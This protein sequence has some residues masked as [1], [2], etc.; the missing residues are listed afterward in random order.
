M[1]DKFNM[2]NAK[3]VSTPL[4]KHFKLYVD[5]CP[6]TNVEVE[7]MSKVL[8][9][10]AAVYLMYVMVCTRPSLTYVVSQVCKFMSNPSK[11]H[12]EAMK[13]SLRYLKDTA[14][15]GIMLGH[16]QGDPSVVGYMD[17]DY[18]GDLD[19]KRFTTGYVFTLARRPI[20]WK[21]II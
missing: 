13:W 7:Y 14:S 10:S 11:R 18:A 12:W 2:S 3:P 5:Q 15:H 9:V 20:C 21:F 19:D 16:Q 17:S 8:D 4:A 1:L 6:K